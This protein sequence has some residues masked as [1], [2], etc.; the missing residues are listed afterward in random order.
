[1]QCS[2]NHLGKAC[3]NI[4]F[5]NNC[6]NNKVLCQEGQ[7]VK[8]MK[9]WILEDNVS[10]RG[11]IDDIYEDIGVVP[12]IHIHQGVKGED[13]EFPYGDRDYTVE[14]ATSSRGDIRNFVL[15]DLINS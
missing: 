11:Y 6:F 9:N 12:N 1:M 13:I 7:V 10:I 14:Y 2:N 4:H 15:T 5:G 3:E 8:L